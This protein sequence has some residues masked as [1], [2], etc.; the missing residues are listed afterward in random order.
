MNSCYTTQQSVTLLVCCILRR[1]DHHTAPKLLSLLWCIITVVFQDLS[2]I[3]MEMSADMKKAVV[4][5]R[6]EQMQWVVESLA[7]S[8]R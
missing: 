3:L 8:S 2:V 7:P 1:Q 4:I 5:S 6:L